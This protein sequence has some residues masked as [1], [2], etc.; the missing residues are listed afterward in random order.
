MVGY[1]DF[2]AV[3]QAQL[4]DPYC[5][6]IRAVRGP[7]SFRVS[8]RPIPASD[9]FLLCDVTL[10][11]ARPIIPEPLRLS[12]FQHFHALSHLGIRPSLFSCYT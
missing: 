12:V 7:S 3:A 10:R 4:S 11:Q 9:L 1:L 6:R 2:I 5:R 8:E